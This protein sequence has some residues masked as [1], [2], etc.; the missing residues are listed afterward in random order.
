MLVH[1]VGHHVHVRMLHQHVGERLELGA[2]IGSA[3]RV[4]RRVE[5]NPLGLRRDRTLELLRRHLE[6][7]RHAGDDF[8]RLA[9]GEQHH[10]GIAHP[11][12]RR[13]DHFI[14]G[15][16][17]RHERVV[18][19]LL[20]AGANGDLARLVVEPVLALEL[21]DDRVLELGDAVD[22]RVFRSLSAFDR[23]DRRLLDVVGRVKIRLAGTKADHVAAG[24]FERARLVRDGDGRRRLDALEL[25]REKGHGN[26]ESGAKMPC[27]SVVMAHCGDGKSQRLMVIIKAVDGLTVL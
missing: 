21:L 22:V 7:A 15:V 13:D 11:I 6:A 3:T 23:L 19:H 9:A 17:R 5:Q 14:A 24:Q 27:R 16:Q 20:A 12:R 4:G 1:I 26:S 25:L 10:F 8:H 2:R 18:Q